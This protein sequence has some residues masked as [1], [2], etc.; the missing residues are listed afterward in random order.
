MDSQRNKSALQRLSLVDGWKFVVN[1]ALT[2][3][4]LSD[5][6]KARGYVVINFEDVEGCLL[7]EVFLR[8]AASS[9][10]IPLS[11][12]FS[13]RFYSMAAMAEYVCSGPGPTWEKSL[14]SNHQYRYK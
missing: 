6:W 7:V 1:H 13:Y 5:W 10:P 3:P 4:A 12:Y 2:G 9:P 11:R 14:D 8:V